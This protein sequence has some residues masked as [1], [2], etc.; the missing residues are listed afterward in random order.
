MMLCRCEPR[1]TRVARSGVVFTT[2]LH[3]QVSLADMIAHFGPH[4]GE[5]TK[6]S[7][8]SARDFGAFRP[9]QNSSFRVES[10]QVAQRTRFL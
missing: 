8:Q 6:I 2:Q 1:N 10:A 5:R 7:E 3:E 4:Y 9:R